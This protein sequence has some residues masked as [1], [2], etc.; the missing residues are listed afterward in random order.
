M[1]LDLTS[2]FDTREGGIIGW[3]ALRR[4]AR[5]ARLMLHLPLLLCEG[6]TGDAYTS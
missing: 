5:G 6:K 2:T 1:E 3:G 4:E